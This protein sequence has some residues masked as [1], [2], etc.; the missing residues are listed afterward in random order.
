MQNN[1]KRSI[2]VPIETW[3]NQALESSKRVYPSLECLTKLEQQELSRRI[4]G[5]I[6][7]ETKARIPYQVANFIEKRLTGKPQFEQRDVL[8]YNGSTKKRKYFFRDP[9]DGDSLM[10]IKEGE[11]PITEG[12]NLI[13]C[14]SDSPCL[15]IKT[16]PVLL[17]LDQDLQYYH[18]GV[19][20]SAIE[21]GGL[22]VH[23][24]PAQQVRVMGYILDKK[25]KKNYVDVPGFVPDVSAHVDYSGDEAVKDRFA[26]EQ[27][28]EVILGHV[29]LKE[30]LERFGIN[31]QDDFGN[32]KLFAVPNNIPMPID[33][34]TWRLVAS[35]GH[36]DRSCVYSAVDAIVKS[37]PTLTSILWITDNEE[38]GDVPPSGA[39]GGFFDLVLDYL[40]EK[41]Y[42]NKKQR[43][44][45]SEKRKICMRSSFL[46]GD[47]NVA[48]SGRDYEL[49]DIKNAPKLGFGVA[50]CGEEGQLST[51]RF[52]QKLREM[53]LRGKERGYNI[54]HQVVGDMD[55][56]DKMDRW[57]LESSA[58]EFVKRI[59]QWG[60]VGIPC[61]S[62]HSPN[63]IICPGDEYATFRFYKRFFDS[64]TGMAPKNKR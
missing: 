27:T 14:H 15:K 62:T 30:T 55:H 44:S 61:A 53:A 46:F 6:D 50:I 63:E 21:H 49:M 5:L 8:E 52:I 64:N 4:A 29:S 45:E 47:V 11:L 33:E 25:G 23:Q 42:M 26:K 7:F 1:G 22:A 58:N 56:Q 3:D 40:C 48:P 41:N 34:Y 28:L 51:K 16:K 17:E 57:Y 39:N 43:I 24:W 59:G 35:Y 2:K 54:C 32:S 18:L 13:L 60:Y 19:R 12:F 31:G 20:L 38:V 10:I 9:W 37:E 36:D